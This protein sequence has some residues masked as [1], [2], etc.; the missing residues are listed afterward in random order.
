MKKK[1]ACKK[2][3]LNRET[4]QQLEE[5]RIEKVA[6]AASIWTLACYTCTCASACYHCTA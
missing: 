5:S 6:G 1:L 3:T 4:L 2:L